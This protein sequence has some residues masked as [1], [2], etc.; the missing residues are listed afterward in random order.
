M[1]AGRSPAVLAGD[2]HVSFNWLS[3]KGD[4]RRTF[5]E[6]RGLLVKDPQVVDAQFDAT[7]GRFGP[8]QS[9]A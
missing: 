1:L 7:I 6:E 3:F 5:R 8:K 4:P 9:Q 2:R